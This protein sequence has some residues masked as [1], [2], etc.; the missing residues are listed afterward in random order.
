M[1]SENISLSLHLNIQDRVALI[2]LRYYIVVIKYH[3][4]AENK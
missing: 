1:D 3:Q 2:K 4:V